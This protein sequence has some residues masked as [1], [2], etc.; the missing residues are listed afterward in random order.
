MGIKNISITGGQSTDKIEN[1]INRRFPEDCHWKDGNCYFF[2]LI[3]NSVFSGK[4]CY[5]P[6][7]GHFLFYSLLY[8]S[9]YDWSGVVELDEDQKKCLIN[10]ETYKYEDPIH[11]NRIV[12]DCIL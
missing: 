2:A 1:F 9:Y 6:I 10:W 4:I 5:D 11:Y 8:D 12:S 3:L 7:D